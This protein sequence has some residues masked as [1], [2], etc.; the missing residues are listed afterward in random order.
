MEHD[1]RLTGSFVDVVQLE[2]AAIEV[3]AGVVGQEAVQ[4]LVQRRGRS[5]L[6]DHHS[7]PS[8]MQL[9]PLPIPRN[10]T[11]SPGCKKRPILGQGG[12][13]RQRDGAHVSQ[14][15]E[16]RKILGLGNAQRPEHRLSVRRADLVADDLVDLV[17]RSS[18]DVARNRSRSA[19]P[20]STPWVRTDAASV[21]VN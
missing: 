1:D 14:I 19:L 15:S 13:Q 12:R 6:E 10:A 11:R 9:S 20:S 2:P 17:R 8:I 18:R 21:A 7:T 3:A 4:D 5:V 16:G